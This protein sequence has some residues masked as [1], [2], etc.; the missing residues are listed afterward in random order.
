MKRTLATYFCVLALLGAGVAAL[1]D[2]VRRGPRR[3]PV[4]P[5]PPVSLDAP[6]V[7]ELLGAGPVDFATMTALRT[8]FRVALLEPL[9]LGPLLEAKRAPPL[10]V[11][12]EDERER[13]LWARA[14]RLG[15]YGR[16]WGS[17]GSGY[18]Y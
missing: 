4:A 2:G 12:E 5:V 6:E 17:G 7:P 14:L 15:I 10:V 11:M 13:E 9:D 18:T 1:A 16:P 3:P 8:G